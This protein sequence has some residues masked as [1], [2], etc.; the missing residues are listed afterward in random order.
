MKTAVKGIFGGLTG[1]F[2]GELEKE[3]T[4][5][6]IPAELKAELQ[7]IQEMGR[8]TLDTADVFSRQRVGKGDLFFIINLDPM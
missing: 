8:V 6:D 1:A 2:E 4:H 3:D 7:A 5:A